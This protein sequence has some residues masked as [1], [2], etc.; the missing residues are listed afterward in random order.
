MMSLV[1]VRKKV[2]LMEDVDFFDPDVTE[3]PFAFY[4]AVR[5]DAPVLELNGPDSEQTLFLVTRYDLVTDV[6]KNPQLYSSGFMNPVGREKTDPEVEAI[7]SDGWP[8]VDTLL[9][10]DPPKH[11]RYRSLVNRAF[12]AKRVRSLTPFIDALANQLVDAFEDKGACEFIASYARPLPLRVI[13]DQFGVP[14]EDLADFKKWSDS[15]VAR[16]GGLL[17]KDEEVACARDVVAL[18]H[19]LKSRIDDCR[20]TPR[21][22]IM[23]D[24]VHAHTD[25]EVPLS[26]A[27]LINMLQQLL[28][29]GNETTAN[30]L[31]GGLGS[32]LQDPDSTKVV[33]EDPGLIEGL[34]EESLRT[35]TAQS[36]M[37]RIA[38]EETDLAGQV[39]PKGATILLRFDAGNRDPAVFENP[40]AF[41]IRRPNTPNHLAFGMGVHFCVGAQLARKE[42]EIGFKVL[43]ARI[44]DIRLA[45]DNDFKHQPNMLLRGLKRLSIEYVKR[46]QTAASF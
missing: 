25:G 33:Y 24:L 34:V 46:D 19:Y 37:W 6:L 28:V 38:T 35:V 31:A 39:I 36:G 12:T 40:E 42:L 41:D 20:V 26:D 23:S 32:L 9:T 16:L 11:R 10:S 7:Y 8:W 18:Q 3:C 2:G 4:Q 17:T 44:K 30:T 43:F 15:F 22:D 14:D 13:A 21:D 1:A 5:K 27:E 45:A 29:A